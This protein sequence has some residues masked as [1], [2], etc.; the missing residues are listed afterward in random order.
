[1]VEYLAILSGKNVITCISLNVISFNEAP[2]I[3]DFTFSQFEDLP[4]EEPGRLSPDKMVPA[5]G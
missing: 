3:R 1:M 2:F 4:K 5:A